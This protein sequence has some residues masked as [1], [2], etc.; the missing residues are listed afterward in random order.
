METNFDV[1]KCNI[2]A[3]QI[4]VI[5]SKYDKKYHEDLKQEIYLKI[6]EINKRKNKIKNYDSYLFISL[7]NHASKYMSKELL[8]DS[9]VEFDENIDY[10]IN[11]SSNSNLLI[12]HLTKAMLQ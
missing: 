2:I 11:I 4:E 12:H 9:Y 7:R 6:L 5:I 3:K 10:K 8:K 1:E